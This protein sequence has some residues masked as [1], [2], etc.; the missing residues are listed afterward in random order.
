MIA[1]STGQIVKWQKKSKPVVA[2]SETSVVEFASVI[3][4]HA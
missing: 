3:G 4:T 1:A 2:L